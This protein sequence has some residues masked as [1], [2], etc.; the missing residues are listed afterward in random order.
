M[1]AFSPF[2]RLP[3]EYM[4]MPQATEQYV[5]VLRVSVRFASLKGRIDAAYALS[6]SPNPSAP[7]VVPATPALAPMTNW[8]RKASIFTV[9]SSLDLGP[10][11]GTLIRLQVIG[12]AFERTTFEL[13]RLEGNFEPLSCQRRCLSMRQPLWS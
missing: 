2:A 6:M 13:F 5:H 1:S 4:M 12:R 7:S 8:R 3:L 10:R 9:Q 11:R